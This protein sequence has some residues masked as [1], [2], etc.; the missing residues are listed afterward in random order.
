MPRSWRS[1]AAF[2]HLLACCFAAAQTFGNS[3]GNQTGF[4]D[5]GGFA[6]DTRDVVNI[7]FADSGGF[8][9][10]TGGN[11]GTGT[12]GNDDS[13]GFTLNTQGDGAA[14]PIDLNQTGFADSGGFN[15]DTSNGTATSTDSNQSGFTDSSGFSLDTTE[16]Q[17]GDNSGFADSGSFELDT[18]GNNGGEN[19]GFGDSGGFTLNT[20]DSTGSGVDLA[21]TGFAESGGFVLDTQHEETNTF[22][23]TDNDGIENDADPD[24]DNDGYPD[25]EEIVAS[26]DPLDGTSLPSVGKVIYVDDNAS[27]ANNGSSWG[28]AYTTLQA[29]LAEAN[30]SVRTQIWVA[31]GVYRPDLGPGQTANNRSSTFQLKNRVEVHGGF[32]GNETNLDHRTRAGD[33]ITVLSGDVGAANHHD[34]N[35]YHVVNA[36]GVDRTAV[37]AN[38]K[39]E[40]GRATGPGEWDKRG[41][42]IFVSDGSPNLR[43]LFLK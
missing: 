29:A 40:H 15:L 17:F 27:G 30:G 43:F 21:N 37:L 13:G 10:D 31:Q 34:D 8:V 39:I 6:L 19:I 3:D 23:D 16:P 4:A 36:S 18:G 41:A 32:T 9:L 20:Q 2:A 14:P 38:F 7:G 1:R 11:D 25:A 42:G 35:A 22:V 12:V 33:W 24:D 28:N 5:S 26:S